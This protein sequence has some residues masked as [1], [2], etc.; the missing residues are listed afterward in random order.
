MKA[1]RGP[2]GVVLL[3]GVSLSARQT[4]S[5]TLSIKGSTAYA[6]PTPAALQTALL[7]VTPAWEDISLKSPVGGKEASG[8]ML[9]GSDLVVVLSNKA[10][11]CTTVFGPRQ[12]TADPDFLILA[13]RVETYLPAQGYH[14]TPIGK[15]IVDTSGT[16]ASLPIDRFSLDATYTAQ[17]RKTISKDGL[18]GNDAK[19]V[20]NRSADGWTAD[21]LLRQDEMVAEGKVPLKS[22]GLASRKKSGGAPLLQEKRLTA[23]AERF[24]M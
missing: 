16:A 5:L 24:G 8:Q 14:T 20:L 18:R 4:P 21:V 11:D 6:Q 17:K 22:C 1:W 12:M 15:I 7:V 3:L 13:G 9:F 2:L 23:A 10:F 19:L